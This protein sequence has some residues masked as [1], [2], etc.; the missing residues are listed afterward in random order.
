MN[1]AETTS[2]FCVHVLTLPCRYPHRL[3]YFKTPEQIDKSLEVLGLSKG[4]QLAFSQ[5]ETVYNDLRS[6]GMLKGEL[7]L[8]V[9][10]AFDAFSKP[11]KSDE[12]PPTVAVEDLGKALEAV[13]V[14][15]TGRPALYER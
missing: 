15:L 11:G 9:Q 10:A 8:K 2:S 1:L 13:D 5:F 14:R 7:L 6:V 4:E 3:E 12:D